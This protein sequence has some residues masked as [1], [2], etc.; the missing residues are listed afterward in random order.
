MKITRF[1]DKM[2]QNLK[3]SNRKYMRGEG[4]GFNIR[5]TPS[6]A[7]TWLYIYTFDEK[8]KELNLG[9]YPEVTLETARGKFEEARK[10]VKNG[11]D[12]SAAA[13]QAK[14]ERRKT[15]TV[16]DL[17][18]EYIARHAKVFKKSWEEDERLLNKEISPIWGK[19][20]AVEIT[21]RDVILVLESIVDRGSPAMS[22]QVLKITRKMFNFAIERD[23]LQHTPF[24]RVKALSPNTRR[25]RNLTEAEIK[26]LWASID[27]AAMSDVA[28]R[29]LKL[30]LVTAQ[31]PGEVSG[32][33]PR[34]IDGRWWTIPA[35]RAKNGEA[36]RVYLTDT[37]LE[38]IGDTNGRGYIF[39]SPHKKKD[40][41]IAA[42]ALP[43]AVRRN[44]KWALFDKDRKPLYDK[45]GKKAT[46]NRFEI[47]QFTPHDLRRTASTFMGGLGFK[48]EIIDA[49]LNHVKLGVIGIYNRYTYDREKQEALES[50][51]RKLLS[52]ISGRECKV[53]PIT[54]A[55]VSA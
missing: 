2:I 48:D 21:K 44:F 25:K 10:L 55:S 1:T 41:P 46:V 49:V 11:I 5:V 4:Y 47:E 22:N 33:H 29:A 54:R 24:F 39:P 53:I 18:A 27:H 35:E 23:I 38:L 12:P 31:R 51:E 19:R 15:P 3:R 42:H 9:G 28:R 36:H 26:T 43:V 8:R 34:E 32:I 52:I 14:E 7:K 16:D 40:Q 50:W 6:G 30:V 17:I 20:K 13:E 37:A 45:N